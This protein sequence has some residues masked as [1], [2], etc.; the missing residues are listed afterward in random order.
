MTQSQKLSSWIQRSEKILLV[1]GDHFTGD[2]V[3]ALLALQ[4]TL[5]K[6]GKEVVAVKPSSVPPIFQFLNGI[7][8]VKNTL[9]GK[10]EILVS[11]PVGKKDVETIDYT[12]SDNIT[13]IVISPQK[14]RSIEVDQISIQKVLSSFDLI[15]TLNTDTLDTLD[16]VFRDY[17][18]L[19]TSTPILNISSS[20]SN[21]FY[22]KINVVDL[23][24]SSTC[25]IVFDWINQD[26]KMQAFLDEEIS[27]ILLTGIISKTESFLA[28]GTSGEAFSIAAE[29]QK[30]GARHSDIIEHLFKMKSLPVLKLWGQVLEN[31]AFDPKHKLSWVAIKSKDFQ[32]TGA[33]STD[34]DELGDYLLRHVQGSDVCVIFQELETGVQVDV[35]FSVVQPPLLP[36]LKAQFSDTQEL[37]NGMRV[38]I[39]NKNLEDVRVEILN[40]IAKLQRSFVPNL[41]LDSEITPLVLGKSTFVE[42]EEG[43][44]VSSKA[45]DNPSPRAPEEIPFQIMKKG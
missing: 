44:I 14:G 10:G 15:V 42:G 25:E 24:K 19:F 21:E 13:D 43:L 7:D 4:T 28:H 38:I 39:Q 16:H 32:S 34:V 37:L 33:N 3:C 9:E 41:S 36:S 6:I 30:R 11:L 20:A 12:I 35:L 18:S 23:T 45:Q 40:D 22:G 26:E 1:T 17:T 5:E 27:T 8:Q 29:L 2:G 31:L